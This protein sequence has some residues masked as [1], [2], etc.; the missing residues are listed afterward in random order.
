MSRVGS[1]GAG[2]HEGGQKG[3]LET[4]RRIDEAG[5]LRRIWS[6]CV[7]EERQLGKPWETGRPCWR[8]ARRSGGKENFNLDSM[9][10][11][12]ASESPSSIT[13]FE[14]LRQL[15]RSL[16]YAANEKHIRFFGLGGFDFALWSRVPVAMAI[17]SQLYLE[18]ESCIRNTPCYLSFR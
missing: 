9:F 13:T 18:E 15:R 1:G 3:P 2:P 17:L 12:S 10:E 7:D 8:I 11:N 16:A 14:A 4:R 6:C 5:R